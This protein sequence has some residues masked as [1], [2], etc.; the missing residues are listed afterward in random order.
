MLFRKFWLL[1]LPTLA[2]GRG[3]DLPEA[4]SFALEQGDRVVFYGDSITAANLYTRNLEVLIRTRY[5]QLKVA[6]HNASMPG[7]TSWGG[8][9]GKTP[10]RI[11]RDVAPFDPTQITVML[12]MNDGGYVSYSSYI[13]EKFRESYE[14]LVSNLMRSNPGAKLTLI[15]SSP[16]DSITKRLTGERAT[17]A[18]DYNDALQKYGHV[19]ASIAERLR[20][21]YLDLN[22]PLAELISE[23]KRRDFMAARGIIPDCTHPC[24]AA[25]LIM[26]AQLFQA[27][28]GDPVVSKVSVN[29]RSRSITE[30]VHA[31][32]QMLDSLRWRQTEQ[33]LPYPTPSDSLS[34]FVLSIE[35]FQREQN[36]EILQVTNL[37]P[38][39]YELTI[40]GKPISVFSAQA[41]RDGVNLADYETPM[42]A[43]AR[44]VER[45]VSKRVLRS[46]NR[47]QAIRNSNPAD[48]A[49]ELHAASEPIELE[50]SRTLASRPYTFELKNVDK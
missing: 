22:E 38:G 20:T 31:S 18:P 44:E 29:A 23:A 33:A 13:E 14:S 43:R 3:P 46:F 8:S 47:W 21:R 48:L 28:N 49:N 42:M 9:F 12:G 45:L 27:W 50:L 1:F 11:R 40:D 26:A 16:Y 19:V 24:S 37:L 6:F 30:T 34:K 35:P 17:F 2:L 41:L 39:N 5:P 25:H 10:E 7:E 36:Q 15:G 4:K 32:A